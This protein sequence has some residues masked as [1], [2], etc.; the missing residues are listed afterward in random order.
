[1][2]SFD[3]LSERQR[4]I[5]R[6]IDRYIA[7]N[8]FPPTIRDIG[9]ATH[10]ASTSVVNYNLNKL[11]QAGYLERAASQSRGLRLVAPIPNSKRKNIVTRM[12]DPLRVQHIGQIAAGQPVAVPSDIGH[13]PDP[14]TAVE[15]T[16]AMLG[17][18]DVSEVFALTVRG[19]SMI[20]AMIQDGDIIILRGITTARNGDMV[21]VWLESRG[22]TT[23]KY[24]HNE[25]E[26]IRLQP[27]HPSMDPIFVDPADC[28]IQGKVVSVIRNMR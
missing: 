13:S 27:A 8:G 10:I 22:E 1:M 17:G 2:K 24:Y 11:V 18:L 9:E 7:D 15:V 20:D 5:L 16:P 26:R 21:A 4:N 23:L 3:K 28:K 14:D 6:F 12:P 19:D 25:G